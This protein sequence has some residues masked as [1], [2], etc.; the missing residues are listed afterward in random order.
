MRNNSKPLKTCKECGYTEDLC[1]CDL[2]SEDSYKE[3]EDEKD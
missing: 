3:D 2:Y 1:I